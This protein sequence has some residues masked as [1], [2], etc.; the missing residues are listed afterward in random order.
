MHWYRHLLT[1]YVLYR[2]S[3][4]ISEIWWEQF[5]VVLFNV[6]HWSNHGTASSTS[7][8]HSIW[9]FLQLESYTLPGYLPNK[10]ECKSSHKMLNM[11]TQNYLLLETIII[12]SKL[13]KALSCPQRDWVVTSECEWRPRKIY[14][15]NL[16][17]AYCE[18]HNTSHGCT[19]ENTSERPRTLRNKR[20]STDTNV[21]WDEDAYD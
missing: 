14:R 21:I 19:A 7:T 1:L 20:V 5:T 9:F 16:S 13:Q 18:S 15:V 8:W 4:S 3:S 12:V 10:V 11:N 2:A 6:N 17:G